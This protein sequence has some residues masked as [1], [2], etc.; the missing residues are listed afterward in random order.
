MLDLYGGPSVGAPPSRLCSE[1]G[2][3][4]TEG[5]PYTSTVFSQEMIYD[6]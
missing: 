1:W 6:K 4:P 3:A 5:R 2:G